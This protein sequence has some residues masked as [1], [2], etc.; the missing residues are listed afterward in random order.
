M[1]LTRQDKEK[2]YKILSVGNITAYIFSMYGNEKSFKK[3]YG[4]SIQKAEKAY[5]RLLVEL[6]KDL[7]R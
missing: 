6:T 5:N 4:F 7:K 1:R 2:L 3:Q